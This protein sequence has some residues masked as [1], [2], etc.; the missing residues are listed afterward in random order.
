M[1]LGAGFACG[2]GS[3]WEEAGLGWWLHQGVQVVSVLPVLLSQV[4]MLVQSEGLS[5]LGSAWEGGRCVL[6][7]EQEH[8]DR[9]QEIPA[10]TWVKESGAQRPAELSAGFS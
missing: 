2:L 4:W 6:P 5:M 10:P 7:P 9:D 3:V 8:L 1:L